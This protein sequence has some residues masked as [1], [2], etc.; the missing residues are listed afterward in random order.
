MYTITYTYTKDTTIKA[1]LIVEVVAP[2]NYFR[3]YTK[4]NG[5]IYY[6]DIEQPNGY[7]AE[8]KQG[9]QVTLTAV[10]EEGYN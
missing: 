6:N 9:E 1:T 10:A 7:Q 3:A 4:G 5:Y 2:K 8:M